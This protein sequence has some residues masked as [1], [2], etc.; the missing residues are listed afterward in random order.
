MVIIHVH[1]LKQIFP[2]HK[3]FVLKHFLFFLTIFPACQNES[4][5]DDKYFAEYGLL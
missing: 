5:T 3:I 1:D 2:Q 4:V